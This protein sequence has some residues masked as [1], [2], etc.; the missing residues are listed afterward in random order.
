MKMCLKTPI[1]CILWIGVFFSRV[2]SNVFTK[3]YIRDTS[4]NRKTVKGAVVKISYKI[5]LK[6]TLSKDVRDEGEIS[7]TYVYRCTLGY[8]FIAEYFTVE[9]FSF[10]GSLGIK[11]KVRLA[12]RQAGNCRHYDTC[13]SIPE[14]KA[15]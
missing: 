8:I 11:K 9:W 5:T 6:I 7:D 14:F 13:F 4:K 2:L 3:I 12:M 10:K 1:K 15:E